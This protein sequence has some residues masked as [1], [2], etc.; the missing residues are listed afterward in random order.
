MNKNKQKQNT[1]KACKAFFYCLESDRM[2]PCRA[3]SPKG[4]ENNVKRYKKKGQLQML[5]K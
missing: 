3:F 1:C 5:R 4:N 2:Y